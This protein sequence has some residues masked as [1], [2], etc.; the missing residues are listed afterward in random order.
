MLSHCIRHRSFRHVAVTSRC[1][2]QHEV[3]SVSTLQEES[4]VP[5]IVI[6]NTRG[7]AAGDHSKGVATEVNGR[8]CS[9]WACC[10]LLMQLMGT[11]LAH[12]HSTGFPF[13]AR[14]PSAPC[15]HGPTR[16]CSYDRQVTSPTQQSTYTSIH[17]STHPSI[18]PSI[19]PSSHSPLA[20]VQCPLKLGLAM[21]S[22]L[23]IYCFT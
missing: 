8:F 14:R 7:W 12:C 3:P 1:C 2:C 23:L 17:P 13:P 18:H 6:T 21:L 22:R 10:M 19:C 15:D 16:V 5:Y 9:L 20:Y 11:N 4:L